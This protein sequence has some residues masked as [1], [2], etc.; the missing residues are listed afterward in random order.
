MNKIREDAIKSLIELSNSTLVGHHVD[1]D[2]EMI[3]AVKIRLKMRPMFIDM[4]HPNDITD[5]QFSLN[6][7]SEIY[8]IPERERNSSTEDVQTVFISKIKV[9]IRIKITIV[10]YDFSIPDFYLWPL[11]LLEV[12][13]KQPIKL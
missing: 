8:K 9:K 11:K 12:N 7:L 3:N 4:M 10:S 13:S 2:V 6:Q 1:F 5:K